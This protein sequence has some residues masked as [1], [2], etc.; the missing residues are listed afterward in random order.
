M[1]FSIS[2]VDRA[3]EAGA[4]DKIDNLTKPK[5]S[6]YSARRARPPHLPDSADA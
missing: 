2:P 5:G 6:L 3:L 4:T 1:K